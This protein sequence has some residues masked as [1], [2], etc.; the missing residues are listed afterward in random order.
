MET[1]KIQFSS[2]REISESVIHFIKTEYWWFEDLNMKSSIED[3]LGITGDDAIEFMEKFAD[4]YKVDLSDFKFTKYFSPEG[5]SGNPL[6][7]LTTIPIYAL[8]LIAF[9]GK[10][11]IVGVLYP[12]SR[13]HSKKIYKYSLTKRINGLLNKIWPNR[14]ERLTV[15]DLVTTALKGKF[16]KKEAVSFEIIKNNSA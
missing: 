10:F 1:V 8:C 9:T 11:V 5:V 4:R 2:L 14:L 3:D 7:A 13:K 12:F 15:E 6:V 16:T